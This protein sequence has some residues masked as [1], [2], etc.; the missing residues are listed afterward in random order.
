VAIEM[1]LNEL[2]VKHATSEREACEQ[3]RSFVMVAREITAR[4][5]AQTVRTE[6]NWFTFEL[7]AGYPIQRCINNPLINLETKLFFLQ[8]AVQFPLLINAALAQERARGMDCSC[9]GKPANGLMAAY[10]L[11][12]LA[13]SFASAPEW[14]DAFVTITLEELLEDDIEHREEVLHHA[15]SPAHV[16]ELHHEWIT[17]RTRLPTPNSGAE[18]WSRRSEYYPSLLFCDAVEGQ[19]QHYRT[20]ALEVTQIHKRLVELDSYTQRWTSG[21]FDPTAI[22]CKVTQESQETL[23]QYAAE[24]TFLC[25]DGQQR[26]FEWHARFTPGA[27]RLHFYP[28]AEA[29]RIIVGYIGPHL[30]TVQNP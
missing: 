8:L 16:T 21:G 24:R 23:N 26:P 6:Q 29:Y 22:A 1:I 17:E 14:R 28:D 15:S 5:V 2:S 19:L 13:V 9:G 10:L 3:L 25:P 7:A 27:G 30:R 4:G 20:G 18:L 12:G 11:D